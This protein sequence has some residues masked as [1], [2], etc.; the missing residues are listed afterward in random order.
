MLRPETL[1]RRSIKIRNAS[2]DQVFWRAV[3]DSILLPFRRDVFE[4][5]QNHNRRIRSPN[6]NPIPRFAM[7]EST[8]FTDQ[9]LALVFLPFH[10]LH[11]IN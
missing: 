4:R 8:P 9:E 10:Q 6:A 1:V 2:V 3:L 5:W 7:G 11:S